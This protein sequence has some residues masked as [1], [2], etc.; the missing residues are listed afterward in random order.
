MNIES[1]I[2]GT[3]YVKFTEKDGVK[4]I[5]LSAYEFTIFLECTKNDAKIL[6]KE[7]LDSIEG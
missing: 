4:G 2:L 1:Y 3:D 5:E 7:L 6:A